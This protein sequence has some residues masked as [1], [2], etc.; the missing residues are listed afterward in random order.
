MRKPMSAFH[1]KP[2]SWLSRRLHSG[3]ALQRHPL[4]VGGLARLRPPLLPLGDVGPD[5]HRLPETMTA[6]PSPS[7]AS[8]H[9]WNKSLPLP[10]VH[11]VNALS[12]NQQ[13]LLYSR[14]GWYCFRFFLFLPWSDIVNTVFKLQ[15]KK[16]VY[17]V[18]EAQSDEN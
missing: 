5:S 1:L 13:R 2:S 15:K 7:P 11:I 12:L 17:N 16:N 9:P 14:E 10:L 6:S 4:P 8:V 18:H 3:K